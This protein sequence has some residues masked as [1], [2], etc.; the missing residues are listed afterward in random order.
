MTLRSL[1]RGMALVAIQCWGQ[2]YLAAQCGGGFIGLRYYLT[3][4]DT[5]LAFSG[6]AFSVQRLDGYETVTFDVDQ[7]WQG[8]TSKRVTLYRP[9][10]PARS[11]AA[12]GSDGPPTAFERGKRYVVFS[13]P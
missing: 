7:T 3:F 1:P 9:L 10:L 12:A 4:R 6:T 2:S 11:S 13:H 5:A 8:S